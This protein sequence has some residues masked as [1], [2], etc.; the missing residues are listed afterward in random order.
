[1]PLL[2]RV[3]LFFA[4]LSIPIFAVASAL[5]LVYRFGAEESD[6]LVVGFFGILVVSVIHSV[7]AQESSLEN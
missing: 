4:E 2:R 1:M 5:A 6:L 7:P 3:L